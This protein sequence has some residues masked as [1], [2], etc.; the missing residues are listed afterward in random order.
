MISII[1]PVYNAEKYLYKCIDSLVNQESSYSYEILLINDG[2]TDMS[3]DICR[4][5]ENQYSNVYVYTQ[6][7]QGPSVARNLGLKKASG[8]WI[9]FVDSDDFVEKDYLKIINENLEDKIDILVFGYY[10]INNNKKSQHDFGKTIIYKEQ[11]LELLANSAEK[12]NLF[13]F[14]VT[15][16]YKR[17]T[18]GLS[19]FDQK[20]TLGEDTI[21]NIEIFFKSNTV[22]IIDRCLYNYVNNEH[23]LTQE[24]YKEDLLTNMLAHYDAR[25]AIYKNEKICIKDYKY[26]LA[27]YYV[28][29]ILFWL[30]KNVKNSP[31]TISKKNELRKI[32]ESDIYFE[33]FKNYHYNWNNPKKSLLIKLFELKLYYLLLKLI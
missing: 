31:D 25:K 22:K 12:M 17:S 21:F 1:I 24:K 23:S 28:N 3:L 9:C 27:K 14:P 26:D 19:K 10:K 29:H 30:I 8:K 33:C 5:Y 16:V 15:K 32:R 20:I 4:E 7:N 6:K 18:I 2:S 13:W 11:I